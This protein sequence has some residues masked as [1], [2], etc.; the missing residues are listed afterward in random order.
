MSTKVLVVES[1]L[2]FAGAM[3]A[4]EPAQRAGD[5]GAAGREAADKTELRADTARL[6]AAPRPPAIG[7]ERL[8]V[9]SDSITMSL[10]GD[11]WVVRV[12]FTYVNRGVA[13][14]A[15]PGCHPPMPPMIEWWDGT[16]WAPAHLYVSAACRSPAYVIAPGA[17]HASA[18]EV[19]IPRDSAGLARARSDHTWR[20]PPGAWLR[21]SWNLVEPSS[22][23]T[24]MREGPPVSERERTSASFRLPPLAET[25]PRTARPI[26]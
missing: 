14:V 25:T 2:L 1:L 22:D 9:A 5:S 10:S 16:A 8:L 21:L 6:D 4:C 18:A 15:N 26:H 13:P 17:R 24:G 23:P 7:D 3:T 12:P 11:V 19:R 20:A